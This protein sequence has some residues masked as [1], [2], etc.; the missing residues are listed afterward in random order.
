MD[1]KHFVGYRFWHCV[2]RYMATNVGEENVPSL[3]T[4][5]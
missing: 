5:T 1:E 3:F 2:I 4:N